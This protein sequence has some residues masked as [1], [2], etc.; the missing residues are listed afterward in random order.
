MKSQEIWVKDKSPSVETNI[1]WIEMYADPQG[2]RG[3]WEGFVSIVDKQ[4]SKKYQLLVNNS[5]QII[6][7]MPWPKTLEKDTF[8][9]PDFSSLDVLTFAAESLPKGINIP[10]YNHIRE[11]VG[12]KNVI[13]ESNKAQNKS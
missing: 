12:F 10:N 7:E 5:G 13:F 11:K 1:G 8:I 4:R 2:S 9:P 6:P 3:L